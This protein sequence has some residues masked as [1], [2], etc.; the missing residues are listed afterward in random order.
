MYP[1]VAGDSRFLVQPRP[2]A[3]Q[4]LFDQRS[5]ANVAATFLRKGVIIDRPAVAALQHR[6]A[7]RRFRMFHHLRR[8]LPAAE[9]TDADMHHIVAIEDTR[10]R[11]RIHRL[12]QQAGDTIRLFQRTV[13]QQ[14]GEVATVIARQQRAGVTHNKGR[15]QVDKRK[16]M[17]FGRRPSPVVP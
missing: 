8:R 12:Q 7:R 3:A 17:F 4:H 10:W 1:P 11:Q 6:V 13:R 9:R 15:E 16:V 5:P 2:A 14:H